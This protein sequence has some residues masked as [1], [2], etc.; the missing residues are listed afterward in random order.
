MNALNPRTHH[1]L[2]SPV[3]AVK[4]H[5]DGPLAF[6]PRGCAHTSTEC[7]SASR[8][9][10]WEPRPVLWPNRPP[11]SRLGMD[12]DERARRPQLATCSSRPCRM[13][14]PVYGAQLIAGNNVFTSIVLVSRANLFP[15]AAVTERTRR[16]RVMH[17]YQLP[18]TSFL[19][20][21]IH[22]H[23]W[24]CRRNTRFVRSEIG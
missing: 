11:I 22:R 10:P 13:F 5:A 9:L 21:L 1:P 19:P 3:D 7:A 14:M 2:P 15:M 16:V 8:S 20:S 18:P 6:L 4:M 23:R 24:A 12:I 17:V